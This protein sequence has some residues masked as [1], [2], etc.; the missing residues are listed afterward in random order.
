MQQYSSTIAP[1][2]E[3]LIKELQK[4]FHAGLVSNIVYR[5]GTHKKDLQHITIAFSSRVCEKKLIKANEYLKTKYSSCIVLT[6][7][8]PNT[9]RQIL[10]YVWK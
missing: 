8:D 4:A 10:M 7:V 6:A 5:E 3:D 1:T 9:E 2:Y